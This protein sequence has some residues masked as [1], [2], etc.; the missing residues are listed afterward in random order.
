M[1]K[2]ISNE[3]EN[4]FIELKDGIN[5][6]IYICVKLAENN[7]D[8][9]NLIINKLQENELIQKIKGNIKEIDEINKANENK[10][11]FQLFYLYK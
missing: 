3:D 10:D 7:E 5:N 1:N 11:I 6:I 4:L 9:F 2:F 8:I